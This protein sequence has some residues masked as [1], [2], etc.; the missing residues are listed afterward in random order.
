MEQWGYTASEL[1]RV[2][3]ANMATKPRLPRGRSYCKW[4]LGWEGAT[5]AAGAV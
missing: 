4:G 2:L 5:G 3:S 1:F